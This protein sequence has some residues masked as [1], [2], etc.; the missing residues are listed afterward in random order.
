MSSVASTGSSDMYP[1]CTEKELLGPLITASV[2]SLLE[3]QAN[4]MPFGRISSLLL[5]VLAQVTISVPHCATSKFSLMGSLTGWLLSCSRLTEPETLSGISDPVVVCWASSGQTVG[6]AAIGT[7]GGT[8][9]H[10]NFCKGMPE[11]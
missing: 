8:S 6:F 7:Y 11:E 9:I 10:D 5:W 4:R 1:S 2:L 3:G